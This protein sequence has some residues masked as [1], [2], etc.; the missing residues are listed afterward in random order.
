MIFCL[1]GVVLCHLC[2]FKICFA[3]PLLIEVIY[4]RQVLQNM[5]EFLQILKYRQIFN[6]DSET[7]IQLFQCLCQSSHFYPAE[8]TPD[9]VLSS[10]SQKF[11]ISNDIFGFL[12]PSHQQFLKI[13]KFL[14][15]VIFWADHALF[16]TIF[17]IYKGLLGA[18]CK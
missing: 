4:C 13:F 1:K 7:D 9:G 15:K 5:Q 2:D 8:F 17:P 11:L 3:N 10:T 18:R 14:K 16:L 12:G 6:L